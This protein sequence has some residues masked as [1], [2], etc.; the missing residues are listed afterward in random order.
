MPASDTD[1]LNPASATLSRSLSGQISRKLGERILDGQL[2]P[3]Q[4]LPDENALCDEFGVSRTAVR[5]AG[6]ML[7]AR[8]VRKVL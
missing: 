5:E 4:L 3:G 7:V 6:K 8:C 1:V 2:L